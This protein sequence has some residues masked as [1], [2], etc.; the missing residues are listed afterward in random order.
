MNSKIKWKLFIQDLV[1]KRMQGG[2]KQPGA[3]FPTGLTLEM[4]KELPVVEA[5]NL[6]VCS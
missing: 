5:G 2:D 1:T 4:Y 3:S 6:L